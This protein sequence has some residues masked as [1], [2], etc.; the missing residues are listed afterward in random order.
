MASVILTHTPTFLPK[1]GPELLA[2]T[3]SLQRIPW[4]SF[5]PA[6]GKAVLLQATEGGGGSC[7]LFPGSDLGSSRATSMWGS[8]VAAVAF[9]CGFGGIVTM[10][11]NQ[12]YPREAKTRTSS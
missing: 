11:D 9:H 1:S 3:H 7:H 6:E 5:L 12:N 10:C 8:G 4:Q 2:F